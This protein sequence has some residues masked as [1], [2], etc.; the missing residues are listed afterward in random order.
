VPLSD[1]LDV[2]A[3]DRTYV[4]VKV[5]LS[6][7]ML[8]LRSYVQLSIV[9]LYLLRRYV[10]LLVGSMI[11]QLI[12]LAVKHFAFAGFRVKRNPRKTRK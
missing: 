10:C 3:A 8:S 4:E 7:Q 9:V 11:T 1:D 5:Q 6:V 2:F 12:I